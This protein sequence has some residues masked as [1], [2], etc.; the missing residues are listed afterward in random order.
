MH[1]YFYTVHAYTHILY[2]SHFVLRF[3]RI[4]HEYVFIWPFRQPYV[5]FHSWASSPKS[6]YQE[7]PNQTAKY[8]TIFNKIFKL[9]FYKTIID[10]LI[11]FEPTSNSKT[12]NKSIAA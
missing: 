2:I 1:T 4:F 10:L 3:T 8:E 9:N 12:Y 7:A 6:P 11:D 5:Y